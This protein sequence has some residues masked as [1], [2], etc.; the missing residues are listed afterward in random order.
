MILPNKA[1]ANNRLINDTLSIQSQR[2]SQ[3]FSAI[4]RPWQMSVV[5]S[6]DLTMTFI[7]ESVDS[8]SS[9]SYTRLLAL[10]VRALVFQLDSGR[11]RPYVTTGLTVQCACCC[12]CCRLQVSERRRSKYRSVD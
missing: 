6:R 10:S 1:A 8:S 7:I 9:S 5:I 2:L 11:Y 4:I 3:Y 12:C